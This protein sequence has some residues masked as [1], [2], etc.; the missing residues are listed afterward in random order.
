MIDKI[1]LVCT[2]NVCRSPM[3]EGILKMALHNVGI[4]DVQV[5]SAGMSALSGHPADEVAQRLMREKGI[6]ISGHRARQLEDSLIEWADL[7]LVM[8]NVQKQHLEAVRPTSRGK[9]YRLGQW[10]N[11]DVADPYR[12]SDTVYEDAVKLIDRCVSDWIMRLNG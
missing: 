10:L 6:D 11:V 8:E 3:G 7:I 2:G 1:L 4:H 9:V 12:L 5:G